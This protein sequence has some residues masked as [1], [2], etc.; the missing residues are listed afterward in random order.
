M[1]FYIV[2]RCKCCDAA[3]TRPDKDMGRTV[4]CERQTDINRPTKAYWNG[5]TNL[6]RFL[7]GIFLLLMLNYSLC[8]L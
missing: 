6:A 8:N 4:W 7:N 1:I 2:V 3:I 5:K